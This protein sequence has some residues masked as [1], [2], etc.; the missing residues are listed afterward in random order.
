MGGE[1]NETRRLAGL[2]GRGGRK[3]E[4]S[5]LVPIDRHSRWG[6]GL[7]SGELSQGE[8]LNSG[9]NYKRWNKLPPKLAKRMRG[10]EG[11][12]SITSCVFINMIAKRREGEVC[13]EICGK[14]ELGSYLIGK[15]QVA[16]F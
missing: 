7:P 4:V 11:N 8:V 12:G 15:E 2:G 5:S 1:E 16:H 14:K 6:G 3:K 13:R 9:R 10:K